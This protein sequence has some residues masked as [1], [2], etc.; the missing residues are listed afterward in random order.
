MSWNN[1]LCPNEFRTIQPFSMRPHLR[2]YGG[3]PYVGFEST[4]PVW[5]E[6]QGQKHHHEGELAFDPVR[7]VLVGVHTSLGKDTTFGIA[8]KADGFGLECPTTGEVG[9]TL[10]IW[11]TDGAVCAPVPP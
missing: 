3:R 8:A 7:C 11:T 5:V 1:G 4:E 9:P 2:E 10:M 6:G